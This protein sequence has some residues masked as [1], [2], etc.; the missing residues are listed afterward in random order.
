MGETGFD[1]AAGHRF[2][3]AHCFNGTWD[4]LDKKERSP[5]DD[6]QMLLRAAA[7]LWHWTQRPDA[8]PESLSVGFWLV[9]RVHAVAGCAEE[10]VRYGELSLAEAAKPGVA[11]YALAY[12]HE[13]LARGH[14]TAGRRKQA[15]DH[16][17]LA[18][19]AADRMADEETKGA[20]LADIATIPC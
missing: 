12:A 5:E 2:F 7:S 10:A 11:P 4:L 3:S 20:L 19:K 18:R 6:E 16:A 14:A 1:A 17:A 9:S 13:A 8:T 15:A